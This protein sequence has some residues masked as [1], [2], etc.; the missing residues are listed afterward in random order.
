MRINVCYDD[1]KPSV[2]PIT[3][4]LTPF[5]LAIIFVGILIGYIVVGFC[6]GILFSKWYYRDAKYIAYSPFQPRT[7]G[8]PTGAYRFGVYVRSVP[9]RFWEDV[10]KLIDHNGTGKVTVPGNENSMFYKVLSDYI[11]RHHSALEVEPNGELSVIGQYQV[12]KEVPLNSLMQDIQ[13]DFPRSKGHRKIQL[14]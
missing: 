5:T 8:L 13:S 12:A 9:K 2:H 14:D 7:P 6:F 11:F 10:D 1:A 4:S 3:L